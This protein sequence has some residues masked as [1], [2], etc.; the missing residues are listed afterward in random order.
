MRKEKSVQL[1]GLI[2]RWNEER[3]EEIMDGGW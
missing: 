3:N 2:E 1:E